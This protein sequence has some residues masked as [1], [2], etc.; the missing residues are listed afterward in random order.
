MGFSWKDK[1]KTN[2]FGKGDSG[3]KDR[4]KDQMKRKQNEKYKGAEIRVNLY[5]WAK[6]KT[7][8][9]GTQYK[10]SLMYQRRDEMKWDEGYDRMRGGV[11]WDWDVR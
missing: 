6:T 8:W 5:I 3:M 4:M 1:K 11:R 2:E 9:G 10:W 7:N